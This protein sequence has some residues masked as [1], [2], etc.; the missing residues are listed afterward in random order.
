MPFSVCL[1]ATLSH[2][3]VAPCYFAFDR[4]FSLRTQARLYY[5]DTHPTGYV[6]PFVLDP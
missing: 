4:D 5:V 2:L 6:A 3:V 1:P